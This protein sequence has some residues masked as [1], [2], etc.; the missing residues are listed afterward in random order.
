MKPHLAHIQNTLIKKQLV[1]EAGDRPTTYKRYWEMIKRAR[2]AGTSDETIIAELEAESA[3][4]LKDQ[5]ESD[6]P[7]F[8][9]GVHNAKVACMSSIEL[10]ISELKGEN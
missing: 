3:R 6:D 2:E 8:Q 4:I 1:V 9:Q 7:M 5:R 10:I